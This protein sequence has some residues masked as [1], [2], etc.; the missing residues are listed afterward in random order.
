MNNK[1]IIEKLTEDM[2]LR[3]FAETTK[4]SYMS[5]TKDVIR[6]FKMKEKEFEEVTID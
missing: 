4:E 2:K 5:K 1:R 6:Y 3:N